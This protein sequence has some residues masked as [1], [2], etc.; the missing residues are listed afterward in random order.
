MLRA[1]RPTERKRCRRSRQTKSLPTNA[2]R[3]VYSA[4]P[5]HREWALIAKRN[6]M[7]PPPAAAAAAAMVL[8]CIVATPAYTARP[9]EILYVVCAVDYVISDVHVHS[10]WPSLRDFMSRQVTWSMAESLACVTH[11]S[12]IELCFHWELYRR[13]QNSD[14]L[15]RICRQC[16]RKSIP[17]QPH[18]HTHTHTH[19]LYIYIYIYIYNI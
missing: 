2:T 15:L 6:W 16:R 4:F 8:S 14:N 12:L 3:R 17:G 13:R 10:A 5:A 7:K 1:L 18:Q 19:T 11:N 9:N